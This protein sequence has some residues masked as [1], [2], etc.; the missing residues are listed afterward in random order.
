M[1]QAVWHSR[2]GD[3]GH[4]NHPPPRLRP[5]S[6]HIPASQPLVMRVRRAW[7]TVT[8]RSGRSLMAVPSV[9]A[10]PLKEAA[11]SLG[12]VQ[13]P[14]RRVQI[15]GGEMVTK[16]DAQQPRPLGH[17]THVP[18]ADPLPATGAYRR[19]W[20]PPS[21]PPA[22]DPLL[23]VTQG[24]GGTPGTLRASGPHFYQT[25]KPNNEE[26]NVGDFSLPTN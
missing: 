2:P 5:Q 20:T 15:W 25:Q 4:R 21:C 1:A 26:R 23:R 16:S 12:F 17:P 11:T 8:L 24:H 10:S 18:L 22:P 7:H 6:P 13:N 3:L 14:G 9:R 19:S